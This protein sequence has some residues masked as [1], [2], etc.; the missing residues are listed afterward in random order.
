MDPLEKIAELLKTH[1]SPI[2]AIESKYRTKVIAIGLLKNSLFNTPE[3][4]EPYYQR[5]LSYKGLIRDHTDN[6]KLAMH[7]SAKI[8]IE[9]IS[10][11][12]ESCAKGGRQ[13]D[14]AL[15]DTFMSLVYPGCD[16]APPEQKRA[17]R[18]TFLAKYKTKE[19]VSSLAAYV[20]RNYLDSADKYDRLADAIVK[21]CLSSISHDDVAKQVTSSDYN[22]F[23][24]GIYSRAEA[25]NIYNI[26]LRVRSEV[27]ALK[28][29]TKISVL[30][31]SIINQVGTKST[32][33]NF[34]GQLW[35][36]LNE[37]QKLF[38]KNPNISLLFY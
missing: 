8:L 30:S 22:Y 13:P 10:A 14:I 5:L 37:I 36:P 26:T 28:Y 6:M 16:A 3:Y 35:E 15:L 9:N 19:Q 34:F 21:R 11:L 1:Y 33:I 18:G 12:L 38:A 17:A 32:T 4:L 23:V 25:T 31:R 29:F 7:I 20:L 24:Y 27:Q 2:K